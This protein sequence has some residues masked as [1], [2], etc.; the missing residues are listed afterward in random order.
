MPKGVEHNS[1]VALVPQSKAVIPSVM[2]K[3]VEHQD[4][5]GEVPA[6]YWSEPSDPSL[7]AMEDKRH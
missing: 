3:G 2:P 6:P 4:K 7:E 1:A 5:L